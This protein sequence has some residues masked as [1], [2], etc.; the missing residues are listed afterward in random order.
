MTRIEITLSK[1]VDSPFLIRKTGRK[2]I[3]TRDFNTAM[4]VATAAVRV[5]VKELQRMRMKRNSR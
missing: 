5:A 2:T 4:R 1:Q 3:R